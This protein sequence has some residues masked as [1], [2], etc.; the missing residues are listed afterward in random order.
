[1][2]LSALSQPQVLPPASSNEKGCP[3]NSSP[4]SCTPLH[5]SSELPE[6]HRGPEGGH[7]GASVVGHAQPTEHS[8]RRHAAVGDDVDAV[9]KRGVASA[10]CGLLEDAVLDLGVAAHDEDPG[11][12]V[13]GDVRGAHRELRALERRQIVLR[14][15][16]AAEEQNPQPRAASRE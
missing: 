13:V 6:P 9:A 4:S 14:L 1:M 7:A 11:L 8:A 10:R 16:A 15:D 3:S 2:Q 12:E 5:R